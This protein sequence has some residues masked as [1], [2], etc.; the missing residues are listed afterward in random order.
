MISQDKDLRKPN[1]FIIGAPKCGTTALASWLEEHPQIFFSPVKEPHYFSTDLRV[2]R[3]PEH[4]RYSALFSG[5]T[6]HHRAVGEGSVYYLFSKDAVRN[7]ENY[8]KCQ[9]KYIVC[10]RNPVKMAPSFHWEQLF[11]GKEHIKPFAKA[12]AASDNRL[13]GKIVRRSYQDVRELAYKEVCKLGFQLARLYNTIPRERVHTVLL[14]DIERDA[15]LAYLSVLNFL[16][17]D[18]DGRSHFDVKNPAKALRVRQLQAVPQLLQR[19]KESVGISKSF[20]FG[21]LIAKA[22][23][24]VTPWPTLSD[25]LRLALEGHFREDILLLE[26]LLRRDLSHWF[27]HKPK[28]VPECGDPSLPG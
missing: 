23:K 2:S 22:N 15:R 20:G 10:L 25:E 8:S 6:H 19:I 17:V 11:S 28:T 21:G 14:D 4:D 12:W 24:K 27:E 26:H 16:G 3:I 18:D 1:F 9:A 13:Q 5:V 7:I